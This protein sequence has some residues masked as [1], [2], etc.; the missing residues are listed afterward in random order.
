MAGGLSD[1]GRMDPVT[2][3][4]QDLEQQDVVGGGGP[5]TPSLQVATKQMRLEMKKDK[6]SGEP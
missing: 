4:E 2:I 3:Y 5:R 6:G 1:K